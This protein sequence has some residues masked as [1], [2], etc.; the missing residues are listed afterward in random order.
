MKA[1]I[2]DLDGVVVDT[3]KYHYLAW[4][5]LAGELGFEFDI[6]HNERLKGVSRMESL[7]IV[8]ETGGVKG[9]TEEEKQDLLPG[10]A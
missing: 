5:K 6:S 2:F 4:R 10:S 3:A 8:L 1:V 9:F 7:N